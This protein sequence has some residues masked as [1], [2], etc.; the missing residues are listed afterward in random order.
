MRTLTVGIVVFLA[1]ALAAD[2]ALVQPK[3][4]AALL[5]AKGPAPAIFHVGPNM[6]Y[7]GKHIP[8]SVYAGPA[9]RP[10]GLE[11]LKQA[12]GKLAR[13]REVILYCGCCPWSNCPN[14]KPAIQ[15]LKDM[16]F[17]RVKAMFV[18][19]NFAKDWI[20]KGYPVEEGVSR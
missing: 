11:L 4:V 12:A 20:D 8:G 17:T 14:V 13:D 1:A 2:L 19:T 10:E 3:D 15:L 5:A 18:E 7:R 9:S 6:L 16:G